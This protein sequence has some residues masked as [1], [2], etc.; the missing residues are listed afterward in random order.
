MKPAWLSLC[1]SYFSRCSHC[2]S[3]QFHHVGLGFKRLPLCPTLQQQQTTMCLYHEKIT[4]NFRSLA[5][6]QKMPHAIFNCHMDWL[7]HGIYFNNFNMHIWICKSVPRFAVFVYIF[8][9]LF[10]A[11]GWYYNPYWQ[12]AVKGQIILVCWLRL[13]DCKKCFL[14]TDGELGAAGSVKDAYMKQKHRMIW[15]RRH[16]PVGTGMKEQN[17]QWRVQ[18]Q[19]VDGYIMD[20]RDWWQI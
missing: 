9:L 11:K 13:L 14:I 19:F 18:C 15:E 20:E 12:K 7:E 5:D 4:G 3:D 2:Q 17:V 10:Q 1:F 8:I 6:V 16:G